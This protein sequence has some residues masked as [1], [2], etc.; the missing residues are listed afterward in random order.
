MS[1][2]GPVSED[3]MRRFAND[4][5]GALRAPF[6]KGEEGNW[7]GAINDHFTSGA[8]EIA[9]RHGLTVLGIS[10]GYGRGEYRDAVYEPK[11]RLLGLRIEKRPNSGAGTQ[12][13]S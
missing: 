13:N 11:L 5:G 9:N 1:I 3:A 6:Q 2:K 4:I 10:I 8:L 7:H 12:S